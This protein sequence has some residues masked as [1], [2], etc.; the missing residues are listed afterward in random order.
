MN[1]AQTLKEPTTLAATMAAIGRRAREAAAQLA[2]AAPEAKVAALQAAAG[3]VRDRQGMSTP[4][5]ATAS[6]R[7]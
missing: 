7:H 3:A 2:L 5:R 6:A 4:P 1:D